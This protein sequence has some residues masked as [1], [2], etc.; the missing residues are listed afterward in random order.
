MYEATALH[1]QI[2]ERGVMRASTAIVL[3]A[4]AMAGIGMYGPA[5]LKSPA[6]VM[7]VIMGIP[8]LVIY[9]TG[10]FFGPGLWAARRIDARLESARRD[11]SSP[12]I[13]R[14]YGGL[15]LG[16]TWPLAALLARFRVGWYV[17]LASV[18]GGVTMLVWVATIFI[19]PSLINTGAFDL[20]LFFGVFLPFGYLGLM[21]LVAPL[22]ARWR[23]AEQQ[24]VIN[25]AMRHHGTI[26]K[27]TVYWDFATGEWEHAVA[28]FC[29]APILAHGNVIGFPTV[30]T[31]A[32]SPWAAPS[33]NSVQ[34]WFELV[35]VVGAAM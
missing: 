4:T 16:W 33:S 35:E 10:H 12:S 30:V 26:R 1:H 6:M 25:W 28:V 27:R 24:L 23:W 11:R 8:F 22:V 3:V 21:F 34:P 9:Y 32:R 31:A 5:P 18:G 20:S 29:D 2:R 14:L 7:L 19:W 15:L 17:W 13:Y